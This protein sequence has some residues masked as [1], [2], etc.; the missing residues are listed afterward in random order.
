MN[1]V[2]QMATNHVRDQ[3]IDHA[4]TDWSRLLAGCARYR[5]K[6]VS[7]IST[8]SEMAGGQAPIL[9]I[10]RELHQTPSHRPDDPAL[11]NQPASIRRDPLLPET[12]FQIVCSA[13]HNRL[14]CAD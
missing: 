4:S 5:R 3:I 1:D 2:G 8:N 6:H 11:L 9:I 12:F 13:A 10:D 7:L 14:P